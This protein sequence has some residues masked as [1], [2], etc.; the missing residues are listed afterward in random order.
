MKKFMLLVLMLFLITNSLGC[1]RIIEDGQAG[2][3]VNLGKINDYP[4]KS[5]IKF[6]LPVITWIEK[7]NVKTQEI[8]ETANVPS[9]EGLISTIDISVVF[10]TPI[11]NIVPIRKSIGKDYI[12]IVFRPNVRD[13]IRAVVSGYQVKSLFDDTGRQEIS[14]K[15]LERLRRKLEPKGIVIEDVLMRDVKLPGTFAQ[16]IENKLKVEQES[17]QKEFEL[18]KAK[19][20]AEIAVANAEGVAKSNAI[21]ADSLTPE[22][23]KYLWITNLDKGNSEIIYV[24]TEANLPILEA[25]RLK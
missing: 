15:I 14:D 4:V 20:D 7:W 6:F 19:K 2:V 18:Q 21:I 23:L 10:H 9:S 22:Y 5:G 24:P 1:G 3:E 11:D 8:K 25:N 12:D 13:S 16:S 17:M